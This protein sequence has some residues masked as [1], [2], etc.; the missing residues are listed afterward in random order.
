MKT[1]IMSRG[2]RGPAL[3]LLALALALVAGCGFDEQR[4]VWS[5]D[6]KRAAVLN[7]GDF[8]LTDAEGKL[9]PKLAEDVT[10][11]AWLDDSQRLVLAI[12]RH[13]FDWPAVAQE[14]GA[15]KTQEVALAA[16]A[17]WKKIQAGTAWEEA[18]KEFELNNT[19]VLALYLTQKHGAELRAKVDDKTWKQIDGQAVVDVR[20]LVVARIENDQLQ[21][22]AV[23]YHG[24]SDY[25]DIRTAPGGRAVAFVVQTALEKQGNVR[26]LVT[27]IDATEVVE[28]ATMVASFPDWTPDGRSVAYVQGAAE[29][30]GNGQVPQLGALI[31]RRVFAD[32]GKV[33]LDPE[34]QALAG[35]ILT[36]QIRVRC[37]RDG[38]ILFNTAEISLPISKADGGNEREQLFAID[39]SRQSTLVRL[40]PRSGENRL[41]QGLTF[42]EPSPDGRRVLFGGENGEV[43]VLEIVTGEI[44]EVQPAGGDLSGAPQW[45]N[46]EEFSFTRR[47]S[48]KDGVKPAHECDLVLR[49]AD[50]PKKET[51]LSAA[52]PAEMLKAK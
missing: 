46:A 13:V 48:E 5:P 35:C 30:A 23:L 38:R 27:P 16:E 43:M 20:Q 24:L 1:K 32:D 49:R 44:N 31:V 45:R 19:N 8:Y 28:V 40:V 10:R 11:V 26:L 52:W 37:L 33:A 4:L 47:N 2:R 15:A 34:P 14:I 41:P 21:L 42:F 39:P 25:A 18:A 12:A 9:S 6:G 36:G 17:V 50:D 29:S 51:V 22:G 3:A 7:H